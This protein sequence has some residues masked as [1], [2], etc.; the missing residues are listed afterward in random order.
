MVSTGS[1]EETLLLLIDGKSPDFLLGLLSHHSSGKEEGSL[2]TVVE[3]RRTDF[4]HD[5][6]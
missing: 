1:S 4:P 3:G 2:I 5:L 6:H